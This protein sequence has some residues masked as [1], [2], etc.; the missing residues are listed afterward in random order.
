M[1]FLIANITNL[2]AQEDSKNSIDV[3]LWG[4][5]YSAEGGPNEINYNPVFT[6]WESINQN[7]S[8]Y[9]VSEY[10]PLESLYFNMNL[11]IDL[12]IRYK[13]HLLIKLGYDYSNPFGIGGK[14]NIAFTDNSNGKEYTEQK[15][16]GYTSHQIN[17]F[18]GPLIP[19]S[20]EGAEIYLG[21]SPMAPTWITYNEKYTKTEDTVVMT[22]YDKTF[23]GFF[24]S[25]RALVG[26]QISITENL[27][28]GSE[29]VF[30]FLNYMELKSGNLQDYSFR[31]P[32]MKWNFT[33]RYQLK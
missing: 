27:K 6:K 19:I 9:I 5:K 24:G 16:F 29:A 30:A 7:Y 17:Y 12:F 13:K 22:N 23:K 31:F 15:E 28:L 21:F 1:V 3:G 10:K 4:F 26:I 33:V 14:G 20:E 18:I 11:G 2:F 8:D 25:C 32:M